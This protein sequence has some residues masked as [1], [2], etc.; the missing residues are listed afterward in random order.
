MLSVIPCVKISMIWIN[1]SSFFNVQTARTWSS[2]FNLAR[3]PFFFQLLAYISSLCQCKAGVS[4]WCQGYNSLNKSFS[5]LPFS[6]RQSL[7]AGGFLP[8]KIY[9]F[10]LSPQ[11]SV[12]AQVRIEEVFRVSSQT[13]STKPIKISVQMGVERGPVEVDMLLLILTTIQSDF[14]VDL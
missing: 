3:N 1:P 14:S 4:N 11:T 5:R 2:M 10:L 12:L 9:L 13:F 8:Q 6:L 7:T